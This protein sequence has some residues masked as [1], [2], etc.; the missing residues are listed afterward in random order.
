[1]KINGLALGMAQIFDGT[2]SGMVKIFKG[3]SAIANTTELSKFGKEYK[4]ASL[5]NEMSDVNGE[6]SEETFNRIV[7]S[8]FEI[9]TG[10]MAKKIRNSKLRKQFIK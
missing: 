8:T 4:V 9:T 7:D 3:G 1:M 10:S 5:L 6:V 2:I